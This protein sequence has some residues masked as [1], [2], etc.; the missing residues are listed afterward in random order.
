MNVSYIPLIILYIFLS[1]RCISVVD[2]Y[3][4]RKIKI[5]DPTES[6]KYI[7]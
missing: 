4:L 7:I 1:I 3:Y 5:K 6:M 2:I